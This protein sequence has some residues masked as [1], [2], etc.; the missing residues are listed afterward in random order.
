[1]GESYV[2]PFAG[3]V[4]FSALVCSFAGCDRQS[5]WQKG[6]QADLAPDALWHWN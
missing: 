5:F 4:V 1:M 2:P 3:D 6:Q